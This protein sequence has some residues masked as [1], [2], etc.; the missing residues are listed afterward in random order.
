MITINKEQFGYLAI[1]RAEI[2]NLKKGYKRLAKKNFDDL[3]L[4]YDIIENHMILVLDGYTLPRQNKRKSDSE[5][6]SDMT[7]KYIFKEKGATKC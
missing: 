2:Q 4:A 1:K 7:A 6:A 3:V 5:K